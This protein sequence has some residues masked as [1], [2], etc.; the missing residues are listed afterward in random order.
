MCGLSELK[1]RKI[2]SILVGLV[3]AINNN[4]KKDQTDRLILD[5]VRIINADETNDRIDYMAELLT[6]EK[7]LISPD[8]ATCKAPCGNTSDYDMAEFDSASEE[9][10]ELKEKSIEELV[11]LAEL[12]NDKDGELPVIVLKTIAYFG[13]NLAPESY[14]KL[15]LELEDKIKNVQNRR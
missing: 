3:G 1:N 11:T 6:K 15:I 8:C 13:Y 5:A 4:G 9:I 14:E 2:I 12:I 7:Y 10:K